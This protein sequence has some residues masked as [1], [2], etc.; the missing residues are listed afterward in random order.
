MASEKTQQHIQYGSRIQSS[1]YG[2][3]LEISVKMAILARHLVMEAQKIGPKS[4]T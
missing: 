2:S 3:D 4:K 1:T